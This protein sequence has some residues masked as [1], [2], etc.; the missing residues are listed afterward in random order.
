VSFKTVKK[1]CLNKQ[2]N[3]QTTNQKT[4]KGVEYLRN[5]IEVASCPPYAHMYICIYTERWGG[6][7]REGG[8]ER[9]RERDRGG[10]RG[11]RVRERDG[12]GRGGERE[13][14]L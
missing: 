2:T 7:K 14:R 12:G 3:K 8:K 9:E 4:P 1:P 6:G 5:D 13:N 11:E 10:G